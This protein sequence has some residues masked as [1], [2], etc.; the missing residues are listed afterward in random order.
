MKVSLKDV[1]NN[2]NWIITRIHGDAKTL[3]VDAKR[4]FPIADKKRFF[5]EWGSTVYLNKLC[6]EKFGKKVNEM[7]VYNY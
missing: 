3:R 1:I 7:N 6:Q 4:R 2:D 5:S